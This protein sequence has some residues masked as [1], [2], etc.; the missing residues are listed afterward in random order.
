MRYTF[1]G[2]QNADHPAAARFQYTH[3]L[4]VVRPSEV[5]ETAAQVRDSAELA[6]RIGRILLPGPGQSL[7]IGRSAYRLK[8]IQEVIT[9]V[10][11]SM[12]AYFYLDAPP[13]WN[14]VASFLCVLAT[15]A[16]AFHGHS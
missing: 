16:L 6:D 4:R 7:G 9:R 2:R 15:V 3:D 11:F 1:S 8:I 5:P 14:Y 13:R 12:F 10:V